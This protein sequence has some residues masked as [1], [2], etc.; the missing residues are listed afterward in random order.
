MA[1]N[2]SKP[3]MIYYGSRGCNSIAELREDYF[4]WKKPC[5]RPLG[6][7]PK[8]AIVAIYSELHVLNVAINVANANNGNIFCRGI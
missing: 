6:I 5:E 7:R 4:V 8:E 3:A 1:F 2:C